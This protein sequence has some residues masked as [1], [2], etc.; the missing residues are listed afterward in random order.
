MKQQE[1]RGDTEIAKNPQITSTR[2]VYRSKQLEISIMY[3]EMD[4]QDLALCLFSF[5]V[6]V[7]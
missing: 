1:G 7:L 6:L 3:F 2:T 5:P 4:F